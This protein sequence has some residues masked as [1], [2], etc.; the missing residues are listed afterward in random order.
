LLLLICLYLPGNSLREWEDF[1]LLMVFL[2]RIWPEGT[3]ICPQGEF[4]RIQT[5]PA[6]DKEV[7]WRAVN[8]PIVINS[9]QNSL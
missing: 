2:G 6:K 7:L 4:E 1:S 3:I 5:K 8:A 9:S